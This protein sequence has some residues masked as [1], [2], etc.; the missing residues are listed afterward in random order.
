MTDAERAEMRSLIEAQ[1]QTTRQEIAEL[2]ELVRP[3]APDNAIGRIS[4]MDAINNRAINEAS[5]RQKQAK[6]QQLERAQTRVNKPDYGQCTQCGQPIPIG[7]LRL[8]PA[9][10]RCVRC[11]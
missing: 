2:E 10:V 5:L 9:S 7:R 6:L 3:I 1:L 4:R 11:A 8:M